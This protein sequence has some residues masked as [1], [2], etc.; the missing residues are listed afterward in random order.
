MQDDS[1]SNSDL[2][3]DATTE[4]K[5]QTRSRDIYDPHGKGLFKSGADGDIENDSDMEDLLEMEQV[6]LDKKK[7]RDERR[8]LR[9]AQRQA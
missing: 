8:Q 3:D 7:K 4:D 1:D 2:N 9:R 6:L 5:P